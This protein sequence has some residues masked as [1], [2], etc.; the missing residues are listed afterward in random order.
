MGIYMSYIVNSI[1]GNVKYKQPT[2]LLE[3][4]ITNLERTHGAKISQRL[5]VNGSGSFNDVSVYLVKFRDNV[6][7]KIAVR[8]AKSPS[9]QKV[10][11]ANGQ[12][13]LQ[14]G[15]NR[16]SAKLSPGKTRKL[17]QVK[18]DEKFSKRNWDL[19]AAVNLSPQL[20]LYSYIE[21]EING[22]IYLFVCSISEGFEFDLDSFFR[23]VYI[24]LNKDDRKIYNQSIRMQ[25]TN[26]FESMAITHG[27]LCNDIK[28]KNAVI[29][30]NIHAID[31]R[32]IDFD[33]DY[34]K[35][36]ERDHHKR[37]LYALMMQIVFANFILSD[38]GVNI[39]AGYFNS[40]KPKMESLKRDMMRIFLD[41]RNNDFVFT[42]SWYF[43]H[44]FKTEP[45]DPV[46]LFEKMYKKCFEGKIDSPLKT[47]ASDHVVIDIDKMQKQ[48]PSVNSRQPQGEG[49]GVFGIAKSVFEYTKSLIFQNPKPAPMALQGITSDSERL[50]DAEAGVVEKKGKIGEPCTHDKHCYTKKCVD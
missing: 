37:E 20:Y 5:I 41:E 31:V 7:K 47:R 34:C 26:L 1:K 38:Y 10:L 15:N 11:S 48:A 42:G 44:Y 17:Q 14:T 49:A 40:I 3:D 18:E 30:S 4:V 32:L 21:K 2:D 13:F 29:N 8:V 50:R 28:P 35:I 19:A 39:F 22:K 9:Y 45:I 46:L 23:K 33:S 16:Y 43:K 25:L 24:R 36:K 12:S 6:V 27:M